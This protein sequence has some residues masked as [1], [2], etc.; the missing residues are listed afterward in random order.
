[1]SECLRGCIDKWVS[2]L[3]H[4]GNRH[5]V[6]GKDSAWGEGRAVNLWQWYEH[7]VRRVVYVFAAVNGYVFECFDGRVNAWLD[8]LAGVG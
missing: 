5:N 4:V 8:G 3:M 1:M 7:C 6:W 2:A